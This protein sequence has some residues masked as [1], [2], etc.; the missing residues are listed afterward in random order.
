M[1][2]TVGAREAINHYREESG[3]II[4]Q[5]LSLSSRFLSYFLLST[6]A[7]NARALARYETHPLSPRSITTDGVS[8]IRVAVVCATLCQAEPQHD[9]LSSFRTAFADAVDELLQMNGPR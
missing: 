2:S 3:L 9:G 6:R 7:I 1:A 5:F 8:G 4:A